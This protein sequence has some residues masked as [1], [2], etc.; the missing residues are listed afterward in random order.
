MRRLLL[1]AVVVAASLCIPIAGYGTEQ[2][3]EP[4][5]GPGEEL[6]MQNGDTLARLEDGSLVVYSNEGTVKN[7]FPLEAKIYRDTDR[8]IIIVSDGKTV[9]LGTY[10]RHGGVV[11]PSTKSRSGL[12]EEMERSMRRKPEPF[13]HRDPLMD[14]WR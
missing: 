13:E 4:L 3:F 2:L 10:K 11:V 6:I 12:E 5:L 8:N 9:V 14:K 7:T 1:S